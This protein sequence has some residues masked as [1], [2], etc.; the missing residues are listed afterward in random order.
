M[1]KRRTSHGAWV[2]GVATLAG[3]I[4]LAASSVA[5]AEAEMVIINM[6]GVG[7]GLND[8]TYG[9]LRLA[10][11]QY[12]ADQVGALIDSVPSIRIRVTFDDLGCSDEGAV[13]G[14]AG[15]IGGDLNNPNFPEQDTLYPQALAN[16]LAGEHLNS[17]LGAAEIAAVFNS[18]LDDPECFKHT[19]NPHGHGEPHGWCYFDDGCAAGDVP[20]HVVVSHEVIHGLGFSTFVNKSPT[21]SSAELG[22]FLAVDGVP[23]PDIWSTL[24]YDLATGRTWDHPQETQA[25]RAASMT[26]GLA[27]SGAQVSLAAPTFLTDLGTHL[28]GT[29]SETG[30][31][32]MYTPPELEVS[33]VAHWT[34]DVGTPLLMG[35]VIDDGVSG[36]DGLWLALLED[37]GWNGGPPASIPTPTPTPTPTPDP[38]PV[39]NVFT[40]GGTIT[41]TN[42]CAVSTVG[43]TSGGGTALLLAA[44]ALVGLRRR[45]N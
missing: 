6:D 30:Y 10:A 43:S 23:T 11:V 8:P 7:E 2:R 21:A 33:S 41:E 1:T 38:T 12:G 28:Q 13:L 35:P 36:G 34:T 20:L 45:R 22:A 16:A 29:D 32:L 42:A 19:Q 15:S 17:G 3:C 24:I 31:M 27:W 5:S 25:N 14:T 39:P 37:L 40:G 44:L 18:R 26:A 9:A 4:V